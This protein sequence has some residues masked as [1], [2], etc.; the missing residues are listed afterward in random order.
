METKQE[1]ARVKNL[2]AN[3]IRYHVKKGQP[4]HRRRAPW[5]RGRTNAEWKLIKKYGITLAQRNA[6][7]EQQ[8]G[9]CAIC[10]NPFPSSKGT[11]VDHDPI[12]GK[13]RGILC[14]HCN[15][16]IGHIPNPEHLERA[17]NYIRL[18]I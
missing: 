5:V 15:Q 1:M 4:T 6:L 18:H 9:L 16:G 3:R 8:K 13:V 14:Q 17:A 2:E 11:H 12:T 10:S 7:I